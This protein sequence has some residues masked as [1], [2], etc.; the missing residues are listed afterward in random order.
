MADE[1]WALSEEDARILRLVTARV[2][3]ELG[4]LR[5]PTPQDPL[6]KAPDTLVVQVKSG[7]TLPAIS[8]TDLGYKSCLLFQIRCSSTTDPIVYEEMEILPVWADD[9]ETIQAELVV[10]NI[11]G[12]DLTDGDGYF[13]VTRERGGRF[14]V[15]GGIGTTVREALATLSADMEVGSTTASVTSVESLSGGT[16]PSVGTPANLFGLAGKN[17]DYVLLKYRDST[18]S[19][20]VAQVEHHEYDVAVESAGNIV[21]DHDAVNSQV[22]MNVLA[23]AAL[24][25]GGSVSFVNQFESYECVT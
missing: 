8:G 20:F 15:A 13:L 2:L 22:R 18:S 23:K 10:H 1:V 21:L 4:G 24:M 14:L 19:W 25:Y 6:I 9:A 12:Q 3:R 11:L 17:G 16:A 5:N 7:E